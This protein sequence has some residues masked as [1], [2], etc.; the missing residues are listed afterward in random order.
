MAAGSRKGARDGGA[1][2]GGA[3]GGAGAA[4]SAVV[5]AGL[6]VIIALA[7]LS[8]VGIPLLRSM[9]LAAAAVVAVAVLVAVTLLPALLGL[10]GRRATAS[11]LFRRPVPD[12]ESAGG[13]TPMGER[14]AR[15]VTRYRLPVLLVALAGLV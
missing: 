5:F 15:F 6:T 2:R 3:G 7:G 1:G 12:P 11:R 4:G 14:W 9:G 8:V 10:F 13:P